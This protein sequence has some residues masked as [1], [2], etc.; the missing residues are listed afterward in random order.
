MKNEIWATYYHKSSSDNNSKHMY[1]PTGSSSWCKWQQAAADNTLESFVHK[2]PPLDEKVLTVIEPIYTSLSSD[3]LL[4][5]CLGSETQNNNESL[6]S[7]IWTFA[8]KH[9]HCG[10]Q[11]IEIANYLAVAIFNEGFLPILKIMDLMGITV[12]TEA[13]SFAVRR[14]EI[15]INRSELR[16]SAASKESRSARLA[17]RTS[18]DQ[19]FEREEGPMYGCGIA[20]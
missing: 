10:T 12:G 3:D 5:R 4:H 18:E 15:R 17:E 7:L 1:C 11:T 16:A 20:D 19:N 14:N 9:I 6:N 8:P 2:H 13:H